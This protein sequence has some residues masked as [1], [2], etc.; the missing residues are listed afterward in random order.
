MTLKQHSYSDFPIVV[1]KKKKT[2]KVLGEEQSLE[3]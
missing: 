3:R 1:K 2:K